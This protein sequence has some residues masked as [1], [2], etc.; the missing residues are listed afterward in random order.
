MNGLIAPTR[1]P[2]SPLLIA[3]VLTS[4]ATTA[5]DS[6]SVDEPPP[7][8]DEPL[9]EEGMRWISMGADALATAQLALD[10]RMPGRVLTA[11]ES[12]GDVV[13]LSYDAK[14]FHAL[15]ELMHAR[16]HRCGGFAVHDS[17]EAAQSALRTRGNERLAPAVSY[18]LDNAVTVNGLLPELQASRILA[19]IQSL[20]AFQNRYYTS[21]FG[22]QSSD[23][24]FNQWSAIV[25]GR[26]GVAVERFTHVFAQKSIILTIPGT[27]LAN[28]VVV[29]GGHQDSIA[30]GG[31]TSIA[32]GADDD[33][34]GIATITEVLRALVSK[35][36]RPLRTVKFMAYAAEEVGLRGSAD[37][38]AD[39][40]ARGVNVVGVMQLDMTNY[41][42]S[43]KDIWLIQDF[44]NAAQNVFLQ[45]LI[46]TYVGAS[47][48]IDSCGYACSDHASWTRNGYPASMP[49]EATLSQYNPTIHTPNDK[50]DVS[51]NNATHALKF[52]RLGAAY[53]AELAK[54]T[55]GSGP[56]NTSPVL[57]I[58]APAAGSIQ[59]QLVQLT[60][61]AS[62]EQDG[63]LSASIR[64]SSN[65]N[66][67]LG[68]GASLSATLSP[69][70]QIV[71]A[72]VTDSAGATTSTTVMFTVS[73]PVEVLFAEDFEGTTNWTPTGLWHNAVSSVCAAPGY[74]SPVHA[75]YYGND[76]TCN[77]ST[78]A[79]TTGT[80]TSPAI[81]GI[82]TSSTLQFKYYRRV[83]TAAGSY[84]VASVEVVVVGTTPT[85][86]WTR[87]SANPS[88]T[89][90]QDS[91]G[92]SLAPFAGKSIQLRFRFDSRDSLSNAFTGWLVD[93]L[94]VIR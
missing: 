30:A 78:R 88:T 87:S 2:L 26:P 33:A 85:I 13:I 82:Q 76:A 6:V 54:G 19:F 37:I 55:L 66:G 59:P 18:T 45:T 72:A 75:M 31:A 3:L 9:Q 47:W 81:T 94:A 28:E 58:T 79:R 29:I 24:I 89:T 73:P 42:G 4:C 17:L 34:S 86:V 1:T 67:V 80:I 25:A 53:L 61:I 35:D 23:F 83:E 57:S 16:H 44:T 49:F 10:E 20:S 60:G 38:A 46:D 70:A 41:K 5:P 22:T 36:Y 15:S 43:N 68:T 62:D 64:W 27:T 92:I 52:A 12:V 65:V 63:V 93:D 77:Y 84:D 39:Y 32:P 71:T 21:L 56:V 91:G 40:L 8:L 90:W 14:D 11:A 50:I 69:G 7:S 48:G 51:G 74:G